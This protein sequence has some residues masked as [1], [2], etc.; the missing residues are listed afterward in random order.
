MTRVGSSVWKSYVEI[1]D[2][3]VEDLVAEL[4]DV[5]FRIVF[6]VQAVCNLDLNRLIDYAQQH[7]RTRDGLLWLS[8]LRIAV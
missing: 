5:A 6:L 3:V 8:A 2:A 1:H 4:S 7:V